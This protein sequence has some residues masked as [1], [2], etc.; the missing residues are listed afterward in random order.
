MVLIWETASELNNAGFEIQLKPAD[1]T[2]DT[3][4]GWQPVAF[5]EGHGTTNDTQRYQYVI[6]DIAPGIYDIRLKQ[7]DFDGTVAYIEPIRI[8]FQTLNEIVL[9]PNYPNPF[10]PVTQIR[11]DLPLAT[12]VSV[13][14]YDVTGRKVAT[15]VDG[16]MVSGRHT[17]TFDGRKND[18][19]ALPSG[20]YFYQLR[21]RGMRITKPM[22]LTK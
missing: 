12:D 5:V 13:A 15:L 10:N 20:T 3:A 1:E 8:A 4:T 11:F 18:G 22:T 14:V 2:A 7:L 21:A 9:H 6:R 16:P 19:A 17:L